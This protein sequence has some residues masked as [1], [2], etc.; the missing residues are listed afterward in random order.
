[1]VWFPSWFNIEQGT[2]GLANEQHVA[3]VGAGRYV[4]GFVQPT[5]VYCLHGVLCDNVLLKVLFSRPRYVMGRCWMRRTHPVY[6]VHDGFS[7]VVCY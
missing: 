2:A 6:T 5:P 4:V 3:A 7:M 1:M